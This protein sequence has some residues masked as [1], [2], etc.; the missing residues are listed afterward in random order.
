MTT[1]NDYIRMFA[2]DGNAELP[3]DGSAAFVAFLAN[4]TNRP[5][6]YVVHG[7]TELGDVVSATFY[8]RAAAFKAT[9]GLGGKYSVTVLHGVNSADIAYVEEFAI[10]EEFAI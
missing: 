9:E 2:I 10:Y 7:V 3:Y 5:A 1:L 8:D 4:M 6:V